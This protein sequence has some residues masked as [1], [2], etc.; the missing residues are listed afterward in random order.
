MSGMSAYGTQ[1][2]LYPAAAAM[3]QQ[4][5]MASA[6]GNQFQKNY[7]NYG[8]YDLSGTGTQSQPGGTGANKSSATG[9]VDFGSAGGYSAAG[10]P[11]M[12]KGGSAAPG[13]AANSGGKGKTKIEHING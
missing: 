10:N 13:A 4:G 7:S 11:A 3:A 5:G 12:N 8:S 6:G 9:A 2:G 1:P